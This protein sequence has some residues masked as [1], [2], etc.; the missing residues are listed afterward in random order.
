V[1]PSVPVVG[2]CQ[3]A[4]ARVLNHLTIPAYVYV[5]EPVCEDDVNQGRHGPMGGLR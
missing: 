2:Q 5:P 4:H 3:P 1:T